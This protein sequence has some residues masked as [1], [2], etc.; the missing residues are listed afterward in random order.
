LF[1]IV[2]HQSQNEKS[3]LE[4]IFFVIHNKATKL[5]ALLKASLAISMPKPR[6]FYPFIAKSAD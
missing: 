3:I 4:K 1:S 2:S 5:I 6:Y